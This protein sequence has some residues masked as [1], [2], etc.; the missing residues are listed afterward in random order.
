[1]AC[2]LEFGLQAREELDEAG[3][4]MAGRTKIMTMLRSISLIGKKLKGT[5]DFYAMRPKNVLWKG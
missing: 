5:A 4:I 3:L 2:E 1:M